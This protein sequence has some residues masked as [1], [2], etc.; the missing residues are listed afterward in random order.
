MHGVHCLKAE[1]TPDAFADALGAIL[2][3]SIVGPI[4]RRGAAVVGRDFHLDA[5]IPRIEAALPRA[6]RRSRAGAGT[7]GRGL[8]PG[9]PGRAALA[10]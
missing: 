9:D 3:G 5:L 4:A 1:R 6:S 7:L 10:S 8:S 2:D